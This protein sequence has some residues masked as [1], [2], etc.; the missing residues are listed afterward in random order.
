MK[1]V[2]QLKKNCSSF[3]RLYIASQTR[4]GDLDDFF[5]HKNLFPSFLSDCGTLRHGDKSDLLKCFEEIH[6]VV[7]ARPKCDCDII[8]GMV[9]VNITQSKGCKGLREITC[10]A[11]AWKKLSEWMLYGMYIVLIHLKVQQGSRE[12]LVYVVELIKILFSA[13]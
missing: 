7:D 5:A 3:S 9:M 10:E 2:S 13:K 6:P 4:C 12:V 1:I 11:I 8:E